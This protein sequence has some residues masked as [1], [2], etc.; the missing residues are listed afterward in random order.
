MNPLQIK[1]AFLG[2]RFRE[3][4]VICREEIVICREKLSGEMRKSLEN[5]RIPVSDCREHRLGK[6]ELQRKP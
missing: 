2:G 5:N 3:K 6:I 4:I 1:A